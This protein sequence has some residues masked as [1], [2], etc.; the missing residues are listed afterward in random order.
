MK[1]QIAIVAALA[2]ACVSLL[3]FA[4]AAPAA[5]P[6]ATLGNLTGTTPAGGSFTGTLT[7]A[8]FV[9]QNGVATLVGTLSGTYTSPAGA[10]SD[11]TNQAISLPVTAAAADPC[12][13]LDLTLGPLHLDLLG[14]NVDLNRV[15]L[16][17]TGQTGPG[18]LLGNLLCGLANALNGSGGAGG[19]VNSL[20]RI[21]GA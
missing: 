12:T 21:L 4:P 8:H 2:T 19:L 18:N 13:I 14:L 10:T 5:P 15:H 3:A 17:I 6:S 16:T 9:K 11:V 20:N 7:G 1:K